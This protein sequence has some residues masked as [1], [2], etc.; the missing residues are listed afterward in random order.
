MDK[1]F[2]VV[3]RETHTSLVAGINNCRYFTRF[4]TI[5]FPDSINCSLPHR[6]DLHK[7]S[8]IN[9]MQRAS[10]GITVRPGCGN[11]QHRPL[12]TGMLANMHTAK[13]IPVH[14]YRANNIRAITQWRLSNDQL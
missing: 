8:F 9:A 12:G 1:L 7:R 13:D 2:I 14:V 10:P 4:E 3:F 6:G 11:E 5:Y